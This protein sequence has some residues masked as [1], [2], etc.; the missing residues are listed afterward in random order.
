M[1]SSFYQ[2][3]LDEFILELF[4][5]VSDEEG[6]GDMFAGGDDIDDDALIDFTI[7]AVD[8]LPSSLTSVVLPAF[9][10]DMRAPGIARSCDR[11]VTTSH[12][13]ICTS[14]LTTT[15]SSSRFGSGTVA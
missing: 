15:A 5:P 2:R 12:T 6:D 14:V 11:I 10:T 9:S 1:S 7:E 3:D 13:L 4:G 8:L